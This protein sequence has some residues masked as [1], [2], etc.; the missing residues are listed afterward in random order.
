MDQADCI[1][2]ERHHVPAPLVHVVCS[3][4]SCDANCKVPGAESSSGEVG[5]W[6]GWAFDTDDGGHRGSA[7]FWR[8]GVVFFEC[9]GYGCGLEDALEIV[10]RLGRIVYAL[11]VGRVSVALYGVCD[12]RHADLNILLEQASRRWQP[13]L[14]TTKTKSG[15]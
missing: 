9:A 6:R 11:K 2:V 10:G 13:R 4:H 12:G 3:D 5:D 14:R 8:G 7:A 1:G 15:R